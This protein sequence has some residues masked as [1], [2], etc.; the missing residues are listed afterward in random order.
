MRNNHTPSLVLVKHKLPSQF[1][2]VWS[3][4][5]STGCFVLFI[6]MFSAHSSDNPLITPC[7]CAGSVR[8]VHQN[9]LQKWIKSSDIKCC[10]LCRYEF[11][12]Q[13]KLKPF[14]KVRL[15]TASRKLYNCCSDFGIRRNLSAIG[16][17]SSLNHVSETNV[18]QQKYT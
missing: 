4:N 8:Y 17:F 9:C 6:R 16:Y 12:M 13:T 10:E 18:A 2:K 14:S 7:K 1:E 15:F 11:K 5:C 3:L